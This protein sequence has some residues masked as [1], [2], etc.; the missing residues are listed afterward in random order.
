MHIGLGNN[1]DDE[2]TILQKVRLNFNFATL[3]LWSADLYFWI[4]Q[5]NIERETAQ[6]ILEY[7]LLNNTRA[8]KIC[9]KKPKYSCIYAPEILKLKLAL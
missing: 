2:N 6:N 7:Q 1:F 3:I 4:K 9:T 5:R 8:D